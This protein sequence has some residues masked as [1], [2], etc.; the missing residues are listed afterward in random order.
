MEKYN[1][2]T[3]MYQFKAVMEV[4]KK[5]ITPGRVIAYDVETSGLQPHKDNLVLMQFYMEGLAPLIVDWRRLKYSPIVPAILT[6]LIFNNPNVLKVGHNLSFD[7]RFTSQHLHAKIDRMFDT[8]LAERLLTAG[9]LLDNSLGSVARRYMSLE[10]DKSYQTYWLTLGEGVPTEEALIYAAEDVMFIEDIMRMQLD[11][12]KK[13]GLLEVARL[14][15][16]LLPTLADSSIHGVLIDKE[17]WQ[18]HIDYLRKAGQELGSELI[19][20]LNPYVEKWRQEKFAGEYEEYLIKLAEYEALSSE[21]E[22]TLSHI[23]YQLQQQ[24]STTVYL[25]SGASRLAIDTKQVTAGVR[26]WRNNNP[27]PPKPKMPECGIGDIN[28]K[29]TT[30]LKGALEAMEVELPYTDNGVMDT[31]KEVLAE[32]QEEYPILKDL[33]RFRGLEKLVDSYGENIIQLTDTTGRLHPEFNQLVSTGRMSCVGPN[34]QQMPNNEEGREFRRCFIAPPSY[35]LYAVDY[36]QIE[37]RVLAELSGEIGMLDAF[38]KGDDLHSITCSQMF[39]IPLEEVLAGKESIYKVKRRVAKTINFGIAYGLSAGG[40]FRRAP[41][42]GIEMTWDEAKSYIA[43]WQQANPRVVKWLQR[44][45]KLG[46][47]QRYTETILGRKR[48]INYIGQEPKERY[49]PEWKEWSKLKGRRER[50][51]CNHVIQGTSA[52]ITKSAVVRCQKFIKD[53]GIDAAPIMY[54]HDEI[55]FEVK[56]SEAEEVGARLRQEMVEA[57]KQFLHKVP[58]EVVGVAAERWEH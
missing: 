52:D 9:L 10:L 26:E 27:P 3:N 22:A 32:Y 18:K 42:E 47:M 39:H 31:S 28:L 17:R 41:S 16:S 13:L 33:L 46:L 58:V 57:G 50:Q 53:N 55:V 38:V 25:K 48:F 49:S 6:Q 24:H 37:L 15:M 56:A 20:T 21:R 14:E 8:M 11:K 34:V 43:A 12:L 2:V 1:Y 23:K 45:A 36:S 40:L 51:L 7:Y 19:V 35:C 44:T 29:S 4:W 30:Q 5:A 54:V